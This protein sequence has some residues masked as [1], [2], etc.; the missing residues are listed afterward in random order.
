MATFLS[1]KLVCYFG[2]KW[3]PSKRSPAGEIKVTDIKM[4]LWVILDYL[5]GPGVYVAPYRGKR[6]EGRG[7]AS[8]AMRAASRSWGHPCPQPPCSKERGPQSNNHVELNLLTTWM[9]LEADI[10]YSLASHLD[11][12]LAIR[13]EKQSSHGTPDYQSTRQQFCVIS[14]TNVWKCYDSNRKLIQWDYLVKWQSKISGGNISTAPTQCQ[15][16]LR[17]HSF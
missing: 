14:A 3:L 1:L 9:S 7:P 12:S 17:N 2:T 6:K 5:G 10:V 15:E 16:L 8:P 11:F 13:L 4:G